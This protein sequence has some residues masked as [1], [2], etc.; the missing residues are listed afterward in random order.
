MITSSFLFSQEVKKDSVKVH[1][2]DEVVVTGQLKPQSI[3]KSVFEVKVISSKDIENRAGN[4]LADLLSQ[5]LNIDVFQNASTGKSEINVLGLDGKYFKVLI[6]NIPI[7][8]EEGFG[9]NTDL[10]LINLDDVE[11]IELVQGAMGV[12]YGANALSGVLNI[13][14]KKNQ[15]ING[16]LTPFYK[17]KLWEMNMN[18]LIKD[19]IFSR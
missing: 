4:N 9:N 11:R 12:Q 5:T 10:T 3:K 17:K 16:K 1:V 13:I 15:N 14:T 6:D 18:F 8:N 2:L 19:D 7:V